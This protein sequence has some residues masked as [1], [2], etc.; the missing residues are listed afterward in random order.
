MP[1]ACHLQ[2]LLQKLS[3]AEMVPVGD[4]SCYNKEIER[5]SKYEA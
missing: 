3:L 1:V 5:M 2:N 4:S